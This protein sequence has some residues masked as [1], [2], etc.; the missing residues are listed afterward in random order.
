MTSPT[1]LTRQSERQLLAFLLFVAGALS[2]VAVA[3]GVWFWQQEAKY[4][5]THTDTTLAPTLEKVGIAIACLGLAGVVL[6][7]GCWRAITKR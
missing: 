3:L 1:D 4:A 6:A 2:A 5:S 7:I